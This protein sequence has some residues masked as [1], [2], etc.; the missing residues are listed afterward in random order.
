[1]TY[2]SIGSISSGTMREYD[3]IPSFMSTLDDLKEKLSL[4]QS[5]PELERVKE[6]T[7]LDAVMAKIESRMNDEEGE[8]RDEDDAYW[9]SEEASYDLNEVLFEE[10][11]GFAP[12]FCSFGSHEGDGADYGFWWSK[13]S[14]D[15]AVRDGEV[16][17]CGETPDEE[18]L[19][20]FNEEIHYVA[21][22]SDHGNVELYAIVRKDEKVTLESVY[23]IV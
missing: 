15:E 2:A 1:M 3:L 21:Q 16:F 6:V 7:R 8:L 10:L 13:E 17:V 19:A 18:E 23:G 22:V 5:I 14:F 12:P 4:D 9:S 20:G 11:N